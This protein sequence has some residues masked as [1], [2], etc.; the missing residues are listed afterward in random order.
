MKTPLIILDGGHGKETPGKRSPVWSDGA[1]LF[2]YEFSRDIVHRISDELL[3]L[4]IPHCIL[5]PEV[6]DIPL[7]E[8]VQR[9]NRLNYQNG[10][11]CFLLSIHANAAQKINTA[12]GWE[13]HIYTDKTR[14]KDFAVLLANE[15][16]DEFAPEWKIRQSLSNQPYWI[17][18]LQILRETN[19]PAVLTENFFMD[20]EKD[21]RFILSDE[22]R[23]RIA[24]MHAAAIKRITI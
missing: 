23:D 13:C 20:N 9:A 14:S 4:R 24:R 17:S 1:Q 7:S 5:V 3:R 18:N 8:R 12:T 6:N 10:G 22:G 19:C 11:N 15:A 21:C 16:N 2:E